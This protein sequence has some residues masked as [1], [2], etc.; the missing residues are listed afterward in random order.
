MKR[1]GF[2]SSALLYGL[3]AL[4]LVVMIGTLAVLGNRKLAMDKIK[5][6]ALIKIQTDY[7]QRQNIVA[8]FDGN[9]P[10]QGNTWYDL[11]SNNHNGTKSGSVT[12]NNEERSVNLNRSTITANMSDV[13]PLNS[14][15]ITIST[16]IRVPSKNATNQIIGLWNF[17]GGI[18]A[19]I[20]PIPSLSVNSS[21]VDAANFCYDNSQYHP[22]IS[23]DEL[24]FGVAPPTGQRPNPECVNVNLNGSFAFGK[25]MQLTVTMI[26]N[27]N[28]TVYINGKMVGHTAPQSPMNFKSPTQTLIIGQN[29]FDTAST[30]VYTENGNLVSVSLQ[31]V[32]FEGSIRNFMIY[33]KAINAEDEKQ[34]YQINKVL[35]G[36]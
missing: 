13:D 31:P 26:N 24:P 33:N 11:T 3:L 12:Y 2:I 6:N 8:L 23:N 32:N 34:N 29:A 21:R 19:N 25:Y 17:K 14:S 35:Y 28:I 1:N 36:L 30:N 5:E 22:A 18:F 27:K 16:V 7:A 15:G 10:F 20:G 4:F 9:Q